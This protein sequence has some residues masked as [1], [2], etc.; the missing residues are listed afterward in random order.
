MKQ[1]PNASVQ[2]DKSF[3]T[4]Q[5]SSGLGNRI[6]I[7]DEDSEPSSR[8]IEH[9]TFN[10]NTYSSSSECAP[11]ASHLSSPSFSMHLCH[12][13]SSPSL[14]PE[15]ILQRRLVPLIVMNRTLLPSPSVAE[16]F[17][18]EFP[19]P[20]S[21][22]AIFFWPFPSITSVQILP[23]AS[24]STA[25]TQPPTYLPKLSANGTSLPEQKRSC[26]IFQ[27]H[28]NHLAWRTVCKVRWD[29]LAF[30]CR[31]NNVRARAACLL[32]HISLA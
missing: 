4:N 7:K 8:I 21:V 3:D 6:V 31:H 10:Y 32:V 16:M 19:S 15:P 20:C 26:S 13:D 5:D 2:D 27:L 30:T 12:T 17:P 28:Q 22:E 18:K 23:I 14:S 24:S 1:W 29:L 11:E 9:S 25:P